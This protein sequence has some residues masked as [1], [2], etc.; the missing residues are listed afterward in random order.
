MKTLFGVH[1]QVSYIYIYIYMC[2]YQIHARGFARASY[3][4]RF[5]WKGKR[6]EGESEGL[7]GV[8]G[9][10]GKG[11]CKE[12]QGSIQEFSQECI[13]SIRG[14]S[15]NP[16]DKYLESIGGLHNEYLRSAQ[17]CSKE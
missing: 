12:W 2:I 7:P 9:E 11:M 5:E 1:A 16:W 6:N 13:G 3:P 4:L 8:G 17:G 15:H 10:V 14:L